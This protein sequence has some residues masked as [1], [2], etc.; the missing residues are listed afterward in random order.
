[1]SLRAKGG[2]AIIKE[3]RALVGGLAEQPIEAD[4]P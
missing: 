2:V 3:G 1:V 4:R